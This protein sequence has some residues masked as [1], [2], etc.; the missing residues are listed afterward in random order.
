MFRCFVALLFLFSGALA[1][2]AQDNPRITETTKLV[3]KCL[4]AVVSLPLVT[5]GEKPG[6][7]TVH[8]GSGT[9]ISPLGF[10]LTNAHVVRNAKEGPALFVGNRV[11]KY[12]TICTMPHSDLAVLKLQTEGP[13]PALPIGRSHD[14][15]LGE[16]TLVIGNAGELAHSASTG[17][18]SGL[19]RSTR[20][21]HSILPDV[22]QTSA[23]INGGN[24]G[25][26]LINALGE[27]IGVVSSKKQNADNVGFAIAADH[28]R[29]ILPAVLKPEDRY[30]FWFGAKADPLSARCHISDLAAGSPA[31]E[32]GLQ[33]GDVI[34]KLNGAPLQSAID[35]ALSLIQKKA[36][37]VLQL[38]VER[39]GK[40]LELKCE[41]KPLVLPEAIADEK[42]VPGLLRKE[43]AGQW[44][45]LPDFASLKPV[46]E[47]VVDNIGEEKKF[48][49]AFQ[50]QGLIKIPE[51]GLYSFAIRSD[52]GSRLR[53]AKQL[54]ADNDGNHA[55][56]DV[57]GVIR[58]PVGLH[59]IEVE[60]YQ[61]VGEMELKL[62]WEGPGVPW[63]PMAKDV[64]FTKKAEEMQK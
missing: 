35:L 45:G 58:L 1:S 42:V 18:V 21:E 32:A 39:E 25:G 30:N 38:Q 63:Q 33:R 9:V 14:L 40:T 2:F 20:T 36:G 51:E 3:Q 23:A 57:S 56:R 28:V 15:M 61:G 24:S 27:M 16:P 64:L 31:A 54:I 4:P 49:Y 60:F 11:L 6:T 29:V 50:Y 48:N 44:S 5:P 10:V 37:D 12:Q 34:V 26:P 19:A 22:I 55:I 13:L 53:I 52:D 8:F 46:E 59:P 17:I 43:Y 62:F 41:L 47:K 7:Q